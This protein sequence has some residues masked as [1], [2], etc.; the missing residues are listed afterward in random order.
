MS[1]L[2]LNYIGKSSLRLVIRENEKKVPAYITK[3]QYQ[4]KIRQKPSSTP[5]AIMVVAGKGTVV[6]CIGDNVMVLEVKLRSYDAHWH[7]ALFLTT[8]RVHGLESLI[9]GLRLRLVCFALT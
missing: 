8:W 3:Y 9:Q 1:Y 2:R 7:I 4:S 6:D 5:R